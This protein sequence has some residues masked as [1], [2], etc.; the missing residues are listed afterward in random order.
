MN[1][2]ESKIRVMTVDDHEI[3]RSGIRFVL[4]A[5]DDLVRQKVIKPAV[6]EKIAGPMRAALKAIKQAPRRKFELGHAKDFER[7]AAER[8]DDED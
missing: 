3:M 1:P 6:F 5:F 4:M 7:L 2:K 8:L